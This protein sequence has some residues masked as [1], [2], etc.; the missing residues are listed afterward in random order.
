MSQESPPFFV[1][2]KENTSFVG[3]EEDLE[4]LH[5]A[6]RQRDE[7]VGIVPAGVTGMGGIGKT[8]LA[9]RYVYQHRADYPTASTGS[10]GRI[11]CTLSFSSWVASCAAARAI[12][13]CKGSFSTG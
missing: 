2:F 9:V 4:R 6:L 7:A 1:D 13:C 11:V 8:Q 12:C 5:A 3:R 10:T